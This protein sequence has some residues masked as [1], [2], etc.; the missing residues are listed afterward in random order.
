MGFRRDEG[1]GG[2]LGGIR[3]KCRQE[4]IGSVIADPDN[5]QNRKKARGEH[6]VPRA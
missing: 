4:R 2:D 5:L 3:I 6:K 1:N